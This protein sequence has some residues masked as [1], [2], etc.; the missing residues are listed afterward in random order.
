[1][2]GGGII[3]VLNDLGEG[4]DRA[5][6]EA[7]YQQDHLPDRLG[8][9]GFRHAR[10]YRRSGG[11]GQE[12]FT[13]YETASPEVLRSAAY[14]QRLAAPTPWTLR[15]MPHFRAMNRTV[16]T[17]AADLGGGIGG[18]V[19][20][21]GAAQRAAGAPVLG[22]VAARSGVTR[23]R[24]WSAAGDLPAN[25]EAALRPGGDASFAA[26]LVVEGTEEESVLAAA[27]EAAAICAMPGAPGLYRLIYA[28]A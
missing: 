1:M 13:F 23:L 26:M 17:I 25:P 27:Q 11:A 3:S 10:R 7:W 5:D 22:P 24:L 2:A 12:Y 21:L 9:P 15:M 8:V 18:V 28:S 19:A 20:V 4:C 6:Y 14:L 16:C